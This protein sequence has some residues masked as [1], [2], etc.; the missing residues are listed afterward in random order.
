MGKKSQSYS[1]LSRKTKRQQGLE[2]PSE[3]QTVPVVKPKQRPGPLTLSEVQSEMLRQAGVT[4]GLIKKSVAT[5]EQSLTDDEPFARIQ[6]AKL[7]LQMGGMFPSKSA[8]HSPQ[9]VQV[10]V[11][12]KPFAQVVEATALP[13]LP[14]AEDAELVK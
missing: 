7:I 1:K 14:E 3:E 6:S 10:Q 9:P 8:T 4:L 2:A 11:S 12:F 13:A 5:L